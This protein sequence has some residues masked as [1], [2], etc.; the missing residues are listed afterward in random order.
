[1]GGRRK[2]DKLAMTITEQLD[3]LADQVCYGYC[4]FYDKHQAGEIKK[5]DL[6]ELH[7]NGCPMK[8]V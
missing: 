7:C 1:M 6:K 5:K 2:N 3:Y 4:K 8:E